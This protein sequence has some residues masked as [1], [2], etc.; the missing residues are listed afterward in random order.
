MEWVPD[1][2]ELGDVIDVRTTEANEV[3]GGEV[4]G[5]GDNEKGGGS[6]GRA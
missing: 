2:E 3:V 5:D 4:I 1:E 6:R